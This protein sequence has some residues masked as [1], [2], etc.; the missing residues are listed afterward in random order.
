MIGK[1]IYNYE[2]LSLIGEVGMG[3]VY[4]AENKQ[5]GLKVAVKVLSPQFFNHNEIKERFKREAKTL[6]LL[7]HPHIVKL[8]N[9]YEDDSGL[10][11]IME[12]VDGYTLDEYIEKVNGLIPEE[13][14]IKLFSELLDAVS[15]AH[16][17]GIIHRD[18]KPSNIMIS[19]K[20]VIKILDFGIAKIISDETDHKLTRTGAR[21]GTIA[22][23]SP[24]Q[25]RGQK[26]SKSTDIYS[27]GVI[28][29]QMLTGKCPYDTSDISEFDLTVKIVQE[30]LPK[31]NTIYPHISEDLQAVVDKATLKESENRFGNADLF[32]NNLINCSQS[33]DES[34]KAENNRTTTLNTKVDEESINKDDIEVGYVIS[35]NDEG[36]D[37]SSILTLIVLIGL[38]LLFL[39]LALFG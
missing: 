19:K 8:L 21:L 38:L 34:P 15:S 26:L 25:I 11:L 10:Y 32:K 2:I 9:Y 28:L 6:A 37:I 35:T 13:K 5:I 30:S 3:K 17:S 12:Y 4:L 22:Y 27:L 33:I 20:G 23:M 29:F 14:A 31:M 1:E 16:E 24:E 7:D 36:Y 18:L 39:G